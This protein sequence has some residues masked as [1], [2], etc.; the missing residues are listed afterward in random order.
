MIYGENTSNLTDQQAITWVILNRYH[1]QSSEFGYSLREI[2]GNPKQFNGVNSSQALAAKNPND[3]GWRNATFLACLLCITTDT[4]D[5]DYIVAK[6]KGISNQRHFR[7]AN[8]LYDVNHF[9]YENGKI[10]VK[11]SSGYVSVT[12]ACIAGKGVYTT[13]DDLANACD[14]NL[15]NYNVFFYHK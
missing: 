15:N 4:Y 9:K 10:Y 6:P 7:S 1:A 14:G 13:I 12:N 5:W 8:R 2:C 3:S 11:Y